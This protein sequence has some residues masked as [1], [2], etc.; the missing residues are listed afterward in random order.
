MIQ[1]EKKKACG[2]I[3]LRNERN[4]FLPGHVHGGGDEVSEDWTREDSR[5]SVPLGTNRD[6]LSCNQR[7]G[8]LLGFD[9]P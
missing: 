4:K 3:I 8:D 7:A 6:W 5:R 1:A 9:S 2:L